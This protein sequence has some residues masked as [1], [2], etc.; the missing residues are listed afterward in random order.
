MSYPCNRVHL[1]FE[2]R[3]RRQRKT[4]RGADEISKRN[5]QRTVD[6]S[7][8]SESTTLIEIY[9][10][11]PVK[12]DVDPDGVGGTVREA[13]SCVSSKVRRYTPIHVSIKKSK[14]SE[15]D[16]K[17]SREHFAGRRLY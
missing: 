7:A 15:S 10:P 13:L 3:L 11:G 16:Y 5:V 12:E 1:K 8:A 14:P 4:Y 17:R 2:P 9:Q 6:A